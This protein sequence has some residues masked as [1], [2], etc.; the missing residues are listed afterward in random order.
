MSK[1]VV[2]SFDGKR[3]E[4]KQT[5]KPAFSLLELLIVLAV[6]AGLMAIAWPNLRRPLNETPLTQAAANLRELFDECR[7]QAV[8]RGEMTMIRLQF[9]SGELRL[10]T[11]E[12]LLASQLQQAGSATSEPTG[13]AEPPDPSSTNQLG[14]RKTQVALDY[15][16]QLPEGIVVDEVAWGIT[17]SRAEQE[18]DTTQLP[19]SNSA[20][21]WYVPFLP[22]GTSKDVRVILKDSQ[23]GKRIM[24][25]YQQGNGLMTI[26]K[27]PDANPA[28]SLLPDAEF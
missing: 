18:S 15:R 5:L 4:A 1:P 17:D 22:S 27:V 3:R 21:F 23:S 12:K 20:E 14:K 25:Q 13:S 19:E 7:Y 26:G 24:L 2:N 8:L 28:D 6:I 16:F 9:D 11:W 10:G